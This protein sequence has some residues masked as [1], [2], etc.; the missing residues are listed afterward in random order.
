MAARTSIPVL[1][2]NRTG[3]T[4]IPAPNNVP[5]LVNGNVCPNDGAT[6]LLTLNSDASPHNLTVQFAAGIDGVVAG[7]RVYPIVVSGLRQWI[8][9]FPVQFYGNQLLFSVDSTLSPVQAVSFLGP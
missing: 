2:T 5:D 1:T 7:S 4:L 6:V 9:P 3:L 8:G